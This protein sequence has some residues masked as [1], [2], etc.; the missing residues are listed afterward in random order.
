[1]DLLYYASIHSSFTILLLSVGLADLSY[2]FHF[3]CHLYTLRSLIRY[4]E[5]KGL[6]F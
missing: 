2:G 5:A 4:T 1:M 3:S 6:G